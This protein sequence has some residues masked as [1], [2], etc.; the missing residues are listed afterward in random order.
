MDPAT[1]YFRTAPVFET[2]AGKYGWINQILAVGIGY[3]QNDRAIYAE[4]HKQHRKYRRHHARGCNR[5]H[6]FVVRHRKRTTTARPARWRC[7]HPPGT[8]WRPHCLLSVEPGKARIGAGAA[9][10]FINLVPRCSLRP[11]LGP[12]NADTAHWRG[13]RDRC[14]IGL[15][16][17]C[18]RPA[19]TRAI[20]RA[21][22]AKGFRPQAIPVETAHPLI[23]PL[24]RGH[25]G[26]SL[27]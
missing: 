23:A 12:A 22:R 21:R 10:L 19:A 13:H 24:R 3:R 11:R 2:A 9:A 25:T 16:C 6:T 20:A 15:L 26:S 27:S 1:Y 5:A 7:P 8:R 14:G 17:F 4:R 18:S